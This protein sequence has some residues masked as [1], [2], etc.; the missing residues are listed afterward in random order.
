MTIN[1][2]I[3]VRADRRDRLLNPLHAVGTVVE[4]GECPDPVQFFPFECLA[5]RVKGK[6]AQQNLIG[7]SQG[8]HPG[9]GIDL[10]SVEIPRFAGVFTDMDPDPVEHQPANLSRERPQ[11]GLDQQREFHRIRGFGK[12]DEERVAGGFNFLAFAEAA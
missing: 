4:P 2:R 7:L 1:K 8:L 12:D 6:P 5:C 3:D 9:T 11:P 10:Q